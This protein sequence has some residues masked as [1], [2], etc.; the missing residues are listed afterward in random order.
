M[1]I[2]RD[3]NNKLA[4]SCLFVFVNF[5][6]FVTKPILKLKAWSPCS[7]FGLIPVRNLSFIEERNKILFSVEQEYPNLNSLEDKDEFIWLMSQEATYILDSL[8][9][10][11]NRSSKT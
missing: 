8:A 7:I 5:A 6:N 9:K 3:I 2:C 10:T 1:D 4:L 11:V